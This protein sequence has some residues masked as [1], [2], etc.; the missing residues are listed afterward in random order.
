MLENITAIE[1]Q[2]YTDEIL[3]A[4][5]LSLGVHNSTISLISMTDVNKDVV[6]TVEYPTH[7]GT[8]LDSDEFAQALSDNISAIYGLSQL[9]GYS[10]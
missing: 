2:P 10:N 3:N 7:T 1:V 8:D 6:I 9:L 4:F 5:A